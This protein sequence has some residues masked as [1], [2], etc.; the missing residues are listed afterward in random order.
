[1]FNFCVSLTSFR[2]DQKR[3]V[4]PPAEATAYHRAV[5]RPAARRRDLQRSVECSGSTRALD[6]L[7]EG[8][9]LRLGAATAAEPPPVPL[10][11]ASPPMATAAPRT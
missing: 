11:T 6:E 4:T 3:A 7:I 10:S 9:V 1:M 8:A 5:R 2:N